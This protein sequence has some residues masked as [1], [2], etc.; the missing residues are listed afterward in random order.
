MSVASHKTETIQKSATIGFGASQKQQDLMVKVVYLTI[1]DKSGWTLKQTRK[2]RFEEMRAK[3]GPKPAIS[4]PFGLSEG[5]ILAIRQPQ[6]ERELMP[7][8]S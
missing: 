4:P 2:A 7:P 1:A 3:C 5:P 8:H 6:R